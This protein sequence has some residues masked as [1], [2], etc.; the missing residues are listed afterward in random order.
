MLDVWID[1]IT[2]PLLSHAYLY[3]IHFSYCSLL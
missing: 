2:V 3:L 1:K